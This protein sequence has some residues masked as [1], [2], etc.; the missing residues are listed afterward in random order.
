MAVYPGRS[1]RRGAAVFAA[2]LF[3]FPAA[4]CGAGSD[5]GAHD[6]KEA[7]AQEL[8]EI[9][10]KVSWSDGTNTY[11]SDSST[12]TVTIFDADGNSVDLF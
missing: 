5:S 10:S 6:K 7:P 3:L 1:I 12:H 2:L 9:T 11:I 4:G 8:P